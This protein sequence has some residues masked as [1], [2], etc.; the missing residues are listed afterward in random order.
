MHGLPSVSKESACNAGH[1]GLIPG[2]GRPPGEGNG[3]P[4]QC[5]CLENP[6]DRGAW[7]AAVHGIA[8][9]R[10]DLATKERDPLSCYEVYGIFPDQGSK[11]S[12]LHWKADSLPLSHQG[13]PCLD[14]CN[15]L[16]LVFQF[17]VSALSNS[18][19]NLTCMCVLSPSVM[20]NSLWPHGPYPA[21]FLHQWD[22]P[23]KN[24]GV[25][26]HSL[27]QGIFLIQGSNPY[28]LHFRWILYHLN[29]QGSP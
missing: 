18:L 16:T 21:R 24:T 20:S 13:S 28:L 14:Y 12:L 5:S 2:L 15:S 27:L 26:R 7:Q 6:M 11:P 9:V 8:R 19:D 25:G 29:H 10:H 17:L 1:L 23:G 22:S 3:N 4:L